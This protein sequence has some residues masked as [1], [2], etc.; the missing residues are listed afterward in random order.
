MTKDRFWDRWGSGPD[1]Y[2]YQVMTHD[3]V[4]HYRSEEHIHHLVFQDE[5]GRE[6][7]GVFRLFKSWSTKHPVVGL[8]LE[9]LTRGDTRE[10]VEVD[11]KLEH[12]LYGLALSRVVET[13][14]DILDELPAW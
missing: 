3:L 6:L 9:S 1:E 11:K 10:A 2:D 14:K 12:S 7:H 13:D 8:K 4:S 5:K